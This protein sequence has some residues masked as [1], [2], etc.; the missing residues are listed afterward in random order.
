MSAAALGL[1]GTETAEELW[2]G[3]AVSFADGA[4]SVTVPAR[5]AAY[6]RVR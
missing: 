4:W 6:L 3:R 1:K 5:D 2:L